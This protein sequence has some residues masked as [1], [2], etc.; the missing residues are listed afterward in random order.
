VN[1]FST[2]KESLRVDVVVAGV[3]RAHFRG[4]SALRQP[5]T[6]L[7][8]LFDD[9]TTRALDLKVP[10]HLHFEELEF[11]NSATISCVIQRLIAVRDK[12]VQ[13]KVRYDARQKWQKA[14]FEAVAM[15]RGS[16]GNLEVQSV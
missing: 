12:G 1:Q 10:L 8:S 9:L 13:T 4:R 7:V 3:I 15:L 6:F 5:E 11:F 16:A 2:S 14:F